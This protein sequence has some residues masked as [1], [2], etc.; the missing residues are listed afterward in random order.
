MTK[1]AIERQLVT[2]VVKLSL[3]L[4]R[5]DWHLEAGDTVRIMVIK[6]QRQNDQAII[7]HLPV[8]KGDVLN[9]QA[10]GGES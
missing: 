3:M 7:A 9:A 6:E 2:L 5:T 4:H 8:T 10:D 1:R